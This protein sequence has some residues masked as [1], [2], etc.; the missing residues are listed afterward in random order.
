M[1]FT[2]AT[3]H[4]A[5]CPR[6]KTENLANFGGEEKSGPGLLVTDFI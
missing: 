6:Q 1:G 2:R 5:G 3:I 4:V